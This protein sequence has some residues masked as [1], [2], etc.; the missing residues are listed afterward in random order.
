M[1]DIL[2]SY[3]DFIFGLLIGAILGFGW[4]VAL[5]LPREGDKYERDN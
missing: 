3:W 4:G 1:G 5:T 2:I